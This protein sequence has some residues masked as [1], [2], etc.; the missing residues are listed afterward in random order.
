MRWSKSTLLERGSQ[1]SQPWRRPELQAWQ[2]VLRLLVL[3]RVWQLPAS[4]LQAWLQFLQR[5]VLLQAWRPVWQLQ[6]PSEPVW[7]RPVL[8]PLWRQ[9][10]WRRHWLLASRLVLL[11]LAWQ[12]AW[13]LV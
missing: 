4:R 1:A 10:A 2:Q 12:L 11:L 13:R 7:Q 6:L 8:Q 5:L 3:R 9:Q